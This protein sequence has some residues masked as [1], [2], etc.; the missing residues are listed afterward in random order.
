MKTAHVSTLLYMA[1]ERVPKMSTQ[2]II[3]AGV[4]YTLTSD[5]Y[6]LSLILHELFGGGKR[7]FPFT[8]DH[9]LAVKQVQIYI[10][11]SRRDAPALSLELLHTGLRDLISRGVDSDPMLR[12]LLQDFSAA[13]SRLNKLP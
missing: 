11:K 12:P 10:A 7:F 4:Q 3:S 2:N 1:P 9:P 13:I 6:S 8:E 5:I